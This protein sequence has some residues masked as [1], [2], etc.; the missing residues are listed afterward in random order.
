MSL[1]A[2]YYSV[3][4]V[5]SVI[6]APARDWNVR[7]EQH[8][9]LATDSLPHYTAAPNAVLVL[10]VGARVHQQAVPSEQ[11]LVHVFAHHAER[12]LQVETYVRRVEQKL[13]LRP[14]ETDRG[15]ESSANAMAT[16]DRVSDVRV[17][18]CTIASSKRWSPAAFG[19]SL[20]LVY[21]KA[22]RRCAPATAQSTKLFARH[23]LL[24]GASA[25]CSVSTRYNSADQLTCQTSFSSLSALKC[26]V[27]RT[28]LKTVLFRI[29]TPT[30]RE[31][32]FDWMANRSFSSYAFG[33]KRLCTR[34]S[35]SSLYVSASWKC[36]SRRLMHRLT[37]S[38]PKIRD[39]NIYFDSAANSGP[40][41]N[42]SGM[43][44]EKHETR[45][46]SRL[47]RRRADATGGV[48]AERLRALAEYAN[49]V[50]KCGHRYDSRT[51]ESAGDMR[52]A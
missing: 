26:H 20:R 35:L 51:M 9:P 3:D 14:I 45:P 29:R 23:K 42:K 15:I 10:V 43:R 39:T 12:L 5:A 36:S 6:I 11:Q 21:S 8:A 4:L 25:F 13:L 38:E 7:V 52:F 44:V 1:E 28:R 19:G 30:S 40:D 49:I 18:M 17:S 46:T 31:M 33:T 27:R 16:S 50:C 47:A 37:S 2:E 41:A 32:C 24:V 22:A 34:V 48:W